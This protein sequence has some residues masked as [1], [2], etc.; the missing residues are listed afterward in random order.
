M[1]PAR[2]WRLTLK[3][4]LEA[5]DFK[6]REETAY[7]AE[8]AQRFPDQAVQA[9]CDNNV[10]AVILMSARSAMSFANLVT[11]HNLIEVTS[12]LHYF[13]LSDSVK[14]SLRSALPDV[15]QD[16]LLVAHRPNTEEL[17]ALITRFAAN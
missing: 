8:P 7:R 17:L 3:P 15:H 9:L 2:I 1:S 11:H 16:G 13:C 6:V 10:N 14:E 12:R 5:A 4:H